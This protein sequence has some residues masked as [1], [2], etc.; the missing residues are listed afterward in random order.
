MPTQL[1][2]TAAFLKK[3]AAEGVV[4]DTPTPAAAPAEAAAKPPGMVSRA[5]SAVKEHPVAAAATGGAALLAGVLTYNMLKKK[6]GVQRKVAFDPAHD[7]AD[8]QGASP[9][10]PAPRKSVDVAKTPGKAGKA[11]K[12]A[13]PAAIAAT[14]GGAAG[15]TGATLAAPAA[16]LDA[17]KGGTWAGK[18]LGVSTGSD[19]GDAAAG[20]A[21]ATVGAAG[22]YQLYKKIRRAA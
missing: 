13:I 15:A 5:L 20:A 12:A 21:L 1:E 11:M 2:K 19:V 18:N 4:L 3:I 6:K 22:L 8:L 14:A 7:N 17:S 10:Q 9:A 16:P